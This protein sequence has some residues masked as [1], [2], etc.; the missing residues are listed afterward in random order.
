MEEQTIFTETFLSFH[1]LLGEFQEYQMEQ[2]KDYNLTP[3]EVAVLANVGTISTASEIA[4]NIDVSKALISRSVK[5]LKDKG[6]IEISIS[7]VDKREQKL[8][9]TEKGKELSEEI[10]AINN[11]FYEIAFNGLQS[12]E[13][14]VLSLLL[15]MMY[16]NIL[17]IK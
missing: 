3:N 14:E 16:K 6:Y 8:V 11:D 10:I 9:L 13:K 4:Q 12:Q 17:S 5:S 7:V 15:K 1:K 2:L